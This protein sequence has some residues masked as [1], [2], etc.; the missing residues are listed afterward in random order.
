[1]ADE[2]QGTGG[3]ANPMTDILPAETAQALEKKHGEVVAVQTKAGVAAFRVFTGPEY[4]RYNSAIFDE[5]KR[6]SA[7]KT[8]LCSCV[9]LPDPTVFLGWVDRYPGIIQTCLPHVL[10][11]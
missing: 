9:V 6:T 10:E 1:M 4:D 7:F 3:P 11:L 2:N 5:K 8:L